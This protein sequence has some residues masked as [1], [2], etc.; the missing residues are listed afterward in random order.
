MSAED[1]RLF[2]LAVEMVRTADWLQNCGT[3]A[4]LQRLRECAAAL[5]EGDG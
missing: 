4:E 5:R 2:A 1:A 3:L